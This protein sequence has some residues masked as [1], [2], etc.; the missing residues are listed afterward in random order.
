MTF[1]SFAIRVL[2]RWF[3]KPKFISEKRFFDCWRAS[4]QTKRTTRTP[5]AF[6][7][8]RR[9]TSR[10]T[11]HTH[12]VSYPY[13]YPP[14]SDHPRRCAWCHHPPSPSP[15]DASTG[16]TSCTGARSGEPIRTIDIHCGKNEDLPTCTVDKIGVLFSIVTDSTDRYM[17]ISTSVEHKQEKGFHRTII[18]KI[19][20]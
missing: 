10:T 19:L 18:H 2:F 11:D 3:Q 15:S 7:N 8:Q 9:R 6:Y 20:N 12:A 14:P 5:N 1:G 17:K 4:F 16:V 13:P